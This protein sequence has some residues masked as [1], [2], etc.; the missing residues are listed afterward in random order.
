MSSI[1]LVNL[2]AMHESLR[3][4]LDTAIRGVVERGDFILG[5]DVS[6]FE[7]AFAQYCGVKHCI[8]VASGLDALTLA[9]KGLGIGPGHEVITAAN[10]FI[11]TALAIHHTGAT[12]VLVDHDPQT[13]NLDFR[14][15]S[16]AITSRTRAIVPV[17]LYGQPAEMDAIDAIANEHGLVVVE[18]AAQAHGAKYKGRRCGSLARAAGFS[19][20]PGKNLGGMGDGGAIT[21]NDDELA[22]WL[23]SCRNYGSVVKYYHEV[24]GCNSRLDTVQAAIL[25]TKLPHLDGWNQ[26]RREIAE[27]Y[28]QFLSGS[29]VALPEERGDV[30]HVYHLFVIRCGNRDEL[31]AALQEAGVGAGIHYPLPI[32]RQI[33]FRRSCIVPRPPAFTDRFADEIV[34]L[35]MCPFVSDDQVERIAQIVREKAVVP[36][37]LPAL[38]CAI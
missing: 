38:A 15:L 18:D 24:L 12:P 37:Q 1:P 30:E 31:L 29:N 2:K 28:R 6:E 25:R 5:R 19:F 8:G 13:Y 16:A 36:S 11:A 22:Q 34:S 33:A 3:D 10:T 20:Y 26:R 23:R 9:L 35:P 21:T 27:R 7:Q 17:H 4:E 32:H 14:R